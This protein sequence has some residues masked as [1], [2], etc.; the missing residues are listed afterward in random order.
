MTPKLLVTKYNKMIEYMSSTFT[1]EFHKPGDILMMQNEQVQ[2]NGEFLPNAFVYFFVEGM[3]KRMTLQF[4]FRHK[5]E[6][7]LNNNEALI[8]LFNETIKMKRGYD[9]GQ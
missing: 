6:K 4:N 5:V 9:Q 2:Y 3:Y 1:A 8:L 7:K